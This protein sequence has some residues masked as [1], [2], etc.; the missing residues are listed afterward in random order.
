MTPRR[1]MVGALLAVGLLV[2]V[3]A[4]ERDNLVAIVG[5]LALLA[6]VGATIHRSQRDARKPPATEP[7]TPDEDKPAPDEDKVCPDC[8]ETV[9]AAANVCRYCGYRFDAASS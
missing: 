3:F 9:K 1:A 2:A 5:A 4:F 6:A 7:P 8:A